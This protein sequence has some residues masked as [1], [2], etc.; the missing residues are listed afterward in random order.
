[1]ATKL[2]ASGA[3]QTDADICNAL[4]APV[5][6]T[7]VGGGLHVVIPADFSAQIASGKDVPGCS[8]ARLELE[9]LY[10][11]DAAQTGAVAPNAVTKL[12]LAQ[13]QELTNFKT[14]IASAT[15]VV[16][17]STAALGT[18]GTP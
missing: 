8:Y 4:D 1:M 18:K 11:S 17:G 7:H 16:S 10:V 14:K 6:G 13:A 3:I 5:A 9:G 2:I 12:T 15:V